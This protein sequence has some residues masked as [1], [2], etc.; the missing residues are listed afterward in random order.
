MSSE[1]NIPPRLILILGGARSGKSAFAERLAAG[2]GK[3]V[4]FIATATSGDDEMR[5]RITRHRAS[6]PQEWLTI[7]EPLDLAGA[8]W[9]AYK[10]ADVAILE[11]VTLWLSNILLQQPGENGHEVQ[12]N[13]E[14]RITS[15][16]FDEQ[17]M[18]HIEELIATIQNA[19]AGKTLILVSNEVGLGIVPAYPL[20]RI[21]RDTLGYV[22]QRLARA[23]DRVYLMVA[24]LAV[25]I[26][27]LHQE[28]ML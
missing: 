5:E 25:D 2:S 11:C 9:Q 12:G 7:E 16:L 27:R 28:A 13:E 1:N 17:S 26:K 24:G 20:G 6:R 22:N 14:E 3:T 18:Q 23:A 10:L 15:S 4:A 19:Q 8:L 21:Y